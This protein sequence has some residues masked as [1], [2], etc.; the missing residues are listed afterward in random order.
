MELALEDAGARLTG[1]VNSCLSCLV[2]CANDDSY[3]HAESVSSRGVYSP[4]PSHS[5]PFK[6]PH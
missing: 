1:W 2:P 3:Y 4:A 6:P 5:L